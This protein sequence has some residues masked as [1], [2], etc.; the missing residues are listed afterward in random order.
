MEREE[1]ITSSEYWITKIQI[2][3]YNCAEQFMQEHS[4]N[5]TQFAEYLGVSKGYVTQLLNGDYD[6]RLSKMVELALACGYI[7]QVSFIP[8][9]TIIQK[10]KIKNNWEDTNIRLHKTIEQKEWYIGYDLKTA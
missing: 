9:E 3:L 5:R 7:P 4:K 10:D 1:L 8:K 2:D 6:N